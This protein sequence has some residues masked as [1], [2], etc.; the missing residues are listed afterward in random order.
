MILEVFSTNNREFAGLAEQN[1]LINALNR[2]ALRSN[3]NEGNSA[4]DP[5]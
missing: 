2:C 5:N 3:S 1:R 4:G